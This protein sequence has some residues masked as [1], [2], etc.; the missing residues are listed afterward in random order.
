[1]LSFIPV[2]W[3]PLLLAEDVIKGIFPK[4]LQ[5]KYRYAGRFLSKHPLPAS[6]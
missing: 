1:L 2:E 5:E 3:L 6:K 4:S